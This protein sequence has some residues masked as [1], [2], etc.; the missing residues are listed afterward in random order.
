MLLIFCNYSFGSNKDSVHAQPKYIAVGYSLNIIDMFPAQI[1]VGYNFNDVFGMQ[2][3]LGHLIATDNAINKQITYLSTVHGGGYITEAASMNASTRIAGSN[4]F[5]LTFL[6]AITDHKKNSYWDFGIFYS[7]AKTT[8][9]LTLDWQ[10]DY[11][12]NYKDGYK[13]DDVYHTVGLSINGHA[14][15]MDRLFF[16]YGSEL[17]FPINAPKV[18]DDV[19]QNYYAGSTYTPGQGFCIPFIFRLKVPISLNIGLEYRIPH[20]QKT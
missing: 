18:F 20:K 5:K 13:R 10:Q 6:K 19:V 11:Y 9:E 17:F 12:G 1:S 16:T 7:I 2:I 3:M 8:Q 4:Y 15:I 14:I